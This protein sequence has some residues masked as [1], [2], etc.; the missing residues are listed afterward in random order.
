MAQKVRIN[1]YLPALHTVFSPSVMTADG[2][3]SAVSAPKES[4]F[5]WWVSSLWNE[6]IDKKQMEEQSYIYYAFP[7]I[8]S[9]QIQNSPKFP[10]KMDL[11]WPINRQRIVCCLRMEDI[12]PCEHGRNPLT[13]ESRCLAVRRNGDIKRQR[14]DLARKRRFLELSSM[15]VPS[16]SR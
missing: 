15:F 5:C 11:F 13:D 7:I 10:I 12:L 8:R 1:T 16:P 3:T 4:E 14:C 2:P 6:L 9:K